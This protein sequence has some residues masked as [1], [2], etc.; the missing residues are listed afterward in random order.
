WRP[1]RDRAH[2]AVIDTCGRTGVVKDWGPAC[3]SG[4][5]IGVVNV[6]TTKEHHVAFGLVVNSVF[7]DDVVVERDALKGEA[8]PTFP[9][10]TFISAPSLPLASTL[11]PKDVLKRENLALVGRFVEVTVPDTLDL[12][13]RVELSLNALVRNSNPDDHDTVYETFHFGQNPPVLGKPGWFINPANLYALPYVRTMCGS[14]ARL[15]V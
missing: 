13:A 11:V 6:N 10:P 1:L 15:D 14:R 4:D 2:N 7:I 12:A 5:P 3:Q 8:S 9:P